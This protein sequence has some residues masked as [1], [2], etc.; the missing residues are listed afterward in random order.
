MALW[1]G[2]S[3]AMAIAWPLSQLQAPWT[4]THLA[5]QEN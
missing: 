1:H 5:P 2:N 4:P 3:M